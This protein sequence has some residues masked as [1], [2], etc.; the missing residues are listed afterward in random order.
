MCIVKLE[1][2]KHPVNVMHI[3]YRIRGYDFLSYRSYSSAS[4]HVGTTNMNERS[5]RS[6]AIFSL[7]IESRIRDQDGAVMVSHLVGLPFKLYI[8]LKKNITQFLSM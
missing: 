5:S 7:I 1:I 3:L 6:H 8:Y 2:D 4:R